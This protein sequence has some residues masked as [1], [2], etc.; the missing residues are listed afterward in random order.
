MSTVSPVFHTEPTV[1]IGLKNSQYLHQLYTNAQAFGIY[2]KST[3]NNSSSPTI[4]L[5]FKIIK[6]A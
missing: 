6:H 1:S 5:K 4:P 2:P 3:R